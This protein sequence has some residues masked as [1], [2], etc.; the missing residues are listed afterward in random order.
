M[1]V[2]VGAALSMMAKDAL[3]T[4]L[5][6]AEARGKAVMAGAL[7]AASD[8]AVILCTVFGAGQ[9]ILHGLTVRTLETLA[10]M[11]CVSFVGTIC[12][13]KLGTKWMPDE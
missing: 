10:V 3:G 1:W 4:W 5:T 2:L 12:W 8:I 6:I 9:V 11:L 7:D 13:T